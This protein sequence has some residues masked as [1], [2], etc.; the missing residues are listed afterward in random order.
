MK[1]INPR[2][3]LPLQGQMVWAL[4]IENRK[5]E[6]CGQPAATVFLANTAKDSYG[7]TFLE[8]MSHKGYPQYI[9][10]FYEWWHFDQT[11]RTEDEDFYRSF[12]EDDMVV[13]WMPYYPEDIPV[14]NYIGIEE[15]MKII[16]STTAYKKG[17]ERDRVN[18]AMTKASDDKL[19]FI[20]VSEHKPIEDGVFVVAN[21]GGIWLSRYNET[22]EPWIAPN[23]DAVIS[24]YPIPQNF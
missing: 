15:S 23:G 20:R 2:S 4:K 10:H 22:C 3:Q 9:K 12:N 8:G 18:L 6:R 17:V 21:H 11:D 13:A 14:W 1:W 7:V 16:K 19:F 24:W 5:G